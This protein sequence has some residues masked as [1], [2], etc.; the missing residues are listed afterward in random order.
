MLYLNA[1]KRG[2]MYENLFNLTL[3]SVVFEYMYG[4]SAIEN[5]I[6]L[7]LTSVVF[8]YFFLL[9][10]WRFNNYLTLTSVVFEL[11]RYS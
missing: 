11:L 3:T 4:V 8:E 9:Y 1:N 2:K 6:N 10:D 7:T 5:A